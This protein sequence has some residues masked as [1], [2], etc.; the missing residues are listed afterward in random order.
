M[1]D[2]VGLESGAQAREVGLIHISRALVEND[3]CRA[4]DARGVR[5]C[6]QPLRPRLRRNRG[7]CSV[8]TRWDIAKRLPKARLTE[9]FN[10]LIRFLKSA[11]LT[12]VKLSSRN[13]IFTSE[14]NPR[15]CIDI[16]QGAVSGYDERQGEQR[17]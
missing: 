3:Q 1:P 14:R 4:R 8:E 13:A 9:F 10:E 16:R 15:H 12:T 5:Q 11:E 7:T 17:Y 6:L 2:I